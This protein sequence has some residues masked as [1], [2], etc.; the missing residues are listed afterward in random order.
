[1]VLLT[2]ITLVITDFQQKKHASTE[3]KNITM[4]ISKDKTSTIHFYM[5]HQ[6]PVYI[7]ICI[8]NMMATT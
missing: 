2:I 3:G 6:E 1:M 8:P 5:D 7:T 4:L